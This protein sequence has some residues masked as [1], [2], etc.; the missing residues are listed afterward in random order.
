[1]NMRRIN[2]IAKFTLFIC[3]MIIFGSESHAKAPFTPQEFYRL[4][5]GSG[6]NVIEKNGNLYWGTRAKLGTSSRRYSSIGWDIHLKNSRGDYF[7]MR[8]INAKHRVGKSIVHEQEGGV[9]RYYEYNLYEISKE[10]LIDE[11]NKKYEY[12]SFYDSG[13]NCE[14]DAIIVLTKNGVVDYGPYYLRNESE[15]MALKKKMIQLYFGN[16]VQYLEHNYRNKKIYFEGKKL[17]P[18]YQIT[19]DVNGGVGGPEDQL[20]TH[21]IDV[22]IKPEVPEKEN[23]TFLYWK[24]GEEYFYP[25]QSYVLDQDI[26]MY[27]QWDSHPEISSLDVYMYLENELDMERIFENVIVNDDESDINQLTTILLNEEDVRKELIRLRALDMKA[28]MEYRIPLKYIVTDQSN[29]TALTES[30]LHVF[31]VH[32]PMEDT[33]Y[34]RY[35]EEPYLHTLEE[36]SVWKIGERSELLIKSLREK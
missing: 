28:D 23:A 27:A 12:T 36:K 31:Y 32:E 9:Y 30:V 22:R 16:N 14:F 35:I 20:K 2:R 18:E 6:M 19:Y 8:I 10:K 24:G 13:I 29:Q 26:T 3:I 17:L 11:A 5:G 25:N 1:M 4:S 21:G 33:G 7:D 34:I 15:W